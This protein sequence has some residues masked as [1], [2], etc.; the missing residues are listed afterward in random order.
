LVV[1]R[2]AGDLE[3]IENRREQL[4]GHH[5]RFRR[6]ELTQAPGAA[7]Q[8]PHGLIDAAGHHQFNGFVLRIIGS[9][10]GPVAKLIGH[11]LDLPLQGDLDRLARLDAAVLREFAEG[12]RTGG[13]LLA[14]HENQVGF[15]LV[16]D[17]VFV[18]PLS[19]HRH[20]PE[21]ECGLF[22]N[23]LGMRAGGGNWRANL[24]RLGP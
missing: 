19:I 10:D 4:P 17:D 21:V 13:V 15:A 7:G 14:G 23:R 9:D 11:R 5:V 8:Q 20:G 18:L 2:H 16:A 24:G 1:S 6:A 22:R 12:A 3:G